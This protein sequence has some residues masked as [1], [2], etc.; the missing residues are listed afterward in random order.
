MT[1]RMPSCRR[2]IALADPAGPAPTITTSV[3]MRCSPYSVFSFAI[4]SMHS[5]PVMTFFLALE[6][7][8]ASDDGP[9]YLGGAGIERAAHRI[10][11]SAF[12]PVFCR[13]SVAAE[14][15]HGVKRGLDERFAYEQLRH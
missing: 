5:I 2:H 15:L 9:L 12:D 6:T 11:Q 13:E 3:F 1:A 4:C 7:E 10:P 8:P 14:D